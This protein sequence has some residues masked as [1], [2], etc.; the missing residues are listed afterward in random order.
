MGLVTGLQDIPARNVSILVNGEE[1]TRTD[2]AGRYS[3]S[4][5]K[6]PGSYEI[7]P[8]STHYY[9]EPVKVRI[10]ENTKEIEKIQASAV[11]ICG[12]VFTIQDDEY[13]LDPTNREI[14][15]EQVPNPL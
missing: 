1:Q 2:S 3:L 15:I 7:E 14:Y 9:F 4:F 12:R 6:I 11:Y 5:D 8:E 10:D 13:K